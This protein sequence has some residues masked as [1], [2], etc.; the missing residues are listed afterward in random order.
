MKEYEQTPPAPGRYASEVDVGEGEAAK[1]TQRKLRRRRI[2]YNRGIVTASS[3]RLPAWFRNTRLRH[4][5]VVT[6]AS[7]GP[8]GSR[9]QYQAHGDQG[10]SAHHPACIIIVVII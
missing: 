10:L 1:S 8:R 9:A 4:H 6:S 2:G 5:R 7:F 3:A